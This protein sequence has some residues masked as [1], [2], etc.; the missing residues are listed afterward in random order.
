MQTIKLEI[1]DAKIDIVLNII[2]NLKE[3]VI[4]KYE[5]VN[6][7]IEMRDFSKISKNSFE[8][9]WD[10]EEDSEYDKFL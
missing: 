6:N 1:E 8:A 7:N 10:N 5:I 2:K 4:N 3:D 9:V